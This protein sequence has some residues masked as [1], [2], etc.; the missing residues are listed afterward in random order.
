[1]RWFPVFALLATLAQAEVRQCACDPANPETMKARQ[2]SLCAEAERQPSGVEFFVL[3]DANP[4]KPNRWLVLPRAHGVGGHQ[5]HEL[6]AATRLR[7]WRKVVETAREKFGEDW[8]AAYNGS[9]VRT[10]CHLHIH[11]GRFIRAAESSRFVFVRRL[12]EL[13]A[14][15]DGGIWVHPVRGGFHAHLGEQTVETV[16]VR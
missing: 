5:L 13:P 3:K 11:I 14:P 7:L 16:L 8:G 6:D 1:M 4:R 12:E 2:C 10:Q 15:R 9:Q